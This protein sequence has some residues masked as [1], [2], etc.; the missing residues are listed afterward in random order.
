[1]VTQ[2]SALVIPAGVHAGLKAHLFPGDG[3]EAAAI[4]LCSRSPGVRKRL[5]AQRLIPV[6]H[7]DCATRTPDYI[8]W[9]G[10]YLEDAIDRG[11]DEG[12]SVVLVHSHPGGFFAFS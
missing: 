4:L 8:S 11:E 7:G 5:L 12:L 10:R 1:S 6:P 2:P 3:C 9:P